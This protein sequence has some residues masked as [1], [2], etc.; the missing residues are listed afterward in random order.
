MGTYLARPGKRRGQ[1]MA[2]LEKGEQRGED[3]EG[4]G[5][6]RRRG[7]GGG[8]VHGR[9]AHG[10]LA[11]PGSGRQRPR[12]GCGGPDPRD[13]KGRDRHQEPNN[14]LPRQRLPGDGPPQ[15]LRGVRRALV[16]AL[17][18]P[19]QRSLRGMAL[20]QPGLH[21]AH[22][23]GQLPRVRERHRRGPR[24]QSRPS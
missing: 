8:A 18:R 2:T 17:P 21:H 6:S 12:R 4:A 23:V 15:H 5:R 10:D 22:V 20:P 13:E 9:T 7:R 3:E 14:R 16:L 19:Q 1:V 24:E 11:E